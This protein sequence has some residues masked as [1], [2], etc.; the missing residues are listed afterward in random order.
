MVDEKMPNRK[1]GLSFWLWPASAELERL[2]TQVIRRN[3][4]AF[5]LRQRYGEK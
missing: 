4:P 3:E 1:S 5:A 2:P